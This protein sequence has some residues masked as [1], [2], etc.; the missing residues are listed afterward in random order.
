MNYTGT[1]SESDI[2]ELSVIKKLIHPN[3]IQL[4][5]VIDDPK[6]DKVYLVFDFLEGG[7]IED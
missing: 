1:F 4:H 2:T 6:L 3:I 5:E 7:T